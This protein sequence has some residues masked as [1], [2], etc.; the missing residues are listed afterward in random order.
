MFYHLS[1]VTNLPE[2]LIYF[3]QTHFLLHYFLLV[4]VTLIFTLPFY[5]RFLL[6]FRADT[7]DLSCRSWKAI[8]VTYVDVL[9]YFSSFCI[10]GLCVVAALCC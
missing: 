3:F 7:S 6:Q 2:R 8:S 4:N 10:V 9:S 1:Y 5:L